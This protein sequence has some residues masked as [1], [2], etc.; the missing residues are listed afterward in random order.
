MTDGRERVPEQDL[1]LPENGL[2]L[3]HLTAQEDMPLRGGVKLHFPTYRSRQDEATDIVKRYRGDTEA[4]VRELGKKIHGEWDDYHG[5]SYL[6]FPGEV[7]DG[8]DMRGVLADYTVFT[9][10]SLQ[11]AMLDKASLYA[12]V[13]TATDLTG[14]SLVNANARHLVAPFANFDSANLRSLKAESAVFNFANFHQARMLGASLVGAYLIGV[15][16]ISP[17]M[18]QEASSFEGATV[19]RGGD[20]TESAERIEG[21]AL[22]SRF[23]TDQMTSGAVEAKVYDNENWTRM[24]SSSSNIEGAILR[25]VAMGR[26]DLTHLQAI[27]SIWDQVIADEV[28]LRASYATGAVIAGSSLNGAD[29]NRAWFPGAVIIGTE[30]NGFRPGNIAGTLFIGSDLSQ[31][32]TELDQDAATGGAVFIGKDRHSP[33]I[34][35]GNPLQEDMLKTTA[36]ELPPYARAVIAS[37]AGQNQLTTGVQESPRAIKAGEDKELE[38]GDEQA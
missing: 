38:P 37:L 18:A 8:L 35:E 25:E 34:A 29:T 3:S 32:D 7:L 28:R 27:G 2:D 11:H 21:H 6:H 31:M 1:V 17:N 33:E 10:G 5:M 16:G 23:T 19:L 9:A 4:V 15:R 20:G 24:L 14:A 36:K 22:S 26:A 12:S 13:F 30:L